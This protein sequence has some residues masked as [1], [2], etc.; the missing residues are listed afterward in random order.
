MNLKLYL[1][2]NRLTANYCTC[3]PDSQQFRFW[4]ILSPYDVYINSSWNRPST[5]LSEL[6]W[7]ISLDIYLEGRKGRQGSSGNDFI[8]LWSW[9]SQVQPGAENGLIFF[10][11]FPRWKKAQGNLKFQDL[12]THPCLHSLA[13]DPV[14]SPLVSL[15]KIP[16]E[17]SIN[18]C[19]KL[20]LTINSYLW[21]SAMYV[22]WPEEVFSWKLS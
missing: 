11:F 6:C 17:L 22:L 1:W 12:Q 20:T 13:W 10:F 5:S 9:L 8:T 7:D 18:W 15:V 21:S 19:W 16:G 14:P 2:S 4:M 3:F